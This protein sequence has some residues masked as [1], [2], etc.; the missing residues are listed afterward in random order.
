MG[1]L[2]DLLMKSDTLMYFGSKTNANESDSDR[3]TFSATFHMQGL[4]LM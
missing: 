3:I 4:I 2:Y 1:D